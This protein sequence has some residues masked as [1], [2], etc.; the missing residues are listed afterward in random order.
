MWDLCAHMQAMSQR[1]AAPTP[2]PLYISAP[3]SPAGRRL[4]AGAVPHPAVLVPALP[5]RLPR[6]LLLV[7]AVAIR[8]RSCQRHEPVLAQQPA[9]RRA[10]QRLPGVAHRLSW[11]VTQLVIPTLLSYSS[12]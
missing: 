9:S 11:A 7:C 3:P 4:V 5:H 12:F 10:R 6:V 1:Q 2:L 8:A